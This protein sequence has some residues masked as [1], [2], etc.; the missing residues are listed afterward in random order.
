LKFTPHS[1]PAPA[2][3]ALSKHFDPQ[4]IDDSLG[5]A[6]PIA[7]LWQMEAYGQRMQALDAQAAAALA[8]QEAAA[9]K[10]GGACPADS[11]QSLPGL[12]GGQAAAAKGAAAEGEEEALRAEF[13]KHVTVM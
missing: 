6:I 8:A 2:A 4:H 11:A 5:G 7:Q 9:G 13:E 10:A 12:A 3:E 1:L